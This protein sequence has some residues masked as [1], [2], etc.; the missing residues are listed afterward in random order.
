LSGVAAVESLALAPSPLLM[1]AQTIGL[2]GPPQAITLTNTGTGPLTLAAITVAGNGGVFTIS[3]AIAGACSTTVAV[4]VGASCTINVVATPLAAVNYNGQIRVNYG[5]A[6]AQVA[7]STRG[8]ASSANMLPE[9][10]LS[11]GYQQV[12]ALSA[13][14][15]VNIVNTG[16]GPVLVTAVSVSGGTA[17]A[18]FNFAYQ[19]GQS[20]IGFLPAGASC[21]VAVT[22]QPGAVGT[23]Q[24][25][26]VAAFAPASILNQ[27]VVLSGVGIAPSST[28]LIDPATGLAAT[29]TT[30]GF[31]IQP[32]NSQSTARLILL[33]NSG[34]GSL[35]VGPIGFTGGTAADF[36]QTNTCGTVLVVGGTCQ[37]YVSFT[38]VTAVGASA[39]TLSVS[40]PG[41]SLPM[42]APV[43]GSATAAQAATLAP[44]NLS[45]PLSQTGSASVA[46]TATLTSS[47]ATVLAIRSISIAGPN[48]KDFGQTSNCGTSLAG[49]GSCA[50][51]VVFTP[52]VPGTALLPGS[53]TATLTVVDGSSTH[54][55]LLTGSSQSPAASLSVP[56]AMSSQ[57]G[58]PGAPVSL[59]FSNDGAG[60][61]TIA[62]ISIAGSTARDF[63]QVN[64]CL[65]SPANPPIAAGATCTITLSFTASSVAAETASLTVTDTAGVQTVSLTGT[66]AAP[67]AT[68]LPGTLVFGATAAGTSSVAQTLT[69]SNGGLGPIA[70]LPPS[71]AATSGAV[72]DFGLANAC[73]ASL[74]AGLSCS[75]AVTFAPALGEASLSTDAGA[76][77]LGGTVP[78]T[79]ALSGSV[80]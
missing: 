12:N 20:C 57:V 36:S 52:S 77:T 6:V 53:E 58:S 43:S 73:P 9:A 32:L 15:T 50:I 7:V 5:G 34:T 71:Y 27:S 22:F 2:A 49:N 45:F 60:P 31:G 74:A 79:A 33:V 56:A 47:S 76:L 26:L 55:L 29:A 13:A 59:V 8:V 23:R 42:T 30:L 69:L 78:L 63:T 70:V 66:G 39:T 46:L 10:G 68:L 11:F 65:T 48:A 62:S 25:N 24:S 54:T 1:P 44:A 41:V 21:A 72:S 61:E 37:I 16:L 18:D 80:Q 28:G 40:I 17:P 67:L 51:S 3:P 14:Q 19:P 75:V 35:P 4:P 38:P 64:T